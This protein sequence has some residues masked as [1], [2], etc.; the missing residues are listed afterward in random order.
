MR[1]RSKISY[2]AHLNNMAIK[3]Y[4]LFTIL[5]T[6]LHEQEEGDQEVHCEGCQEAENMI[7]AEFVGEDPS[8]RAL[9]KNYSTKIKNKVIKGK[10]IGRAHV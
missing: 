6:Y 8:K 9:F 1:V 7:Y 2:H 3:E 10:E 5:K 4:F